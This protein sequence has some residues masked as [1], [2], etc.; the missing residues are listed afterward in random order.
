MYS[1]TYSAVKLQKKL[2]P[3][4]ISIKKSFVLLEN[5]AISNKKCTFA[6]KLD[7]NYKDETKQTLFIY[8]R[9]MQHTYDRLRH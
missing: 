2:L 3:N 6:T 8:N 5:L 7:I 4:K 1:L 9:N